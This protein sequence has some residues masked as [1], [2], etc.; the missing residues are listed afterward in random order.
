M[1]SLKLI[2]SVG[3]VE[4]TAQNVPSRHLFRGVNGNRNGHLASWISPCVS[5]HVLHLERMVL[6]FPLQHSSGWPSWS[7]IQ[8]S[9]PN[10]VT[11]PSLIWPPW[12]KPTQTLLYSYFIVVRLLMVTLFSVSTHHSLVSTD[13]RPNQRL[14]SNNFGIMV[15]GCVR[16]A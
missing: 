7:A 11:L 2:T 14:E 13:V 16:L 6:L 12:I 15:R 9:L 4:H 10:I 5:L 8:I 3:Q 1:P